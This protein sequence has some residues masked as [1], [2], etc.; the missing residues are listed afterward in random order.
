MLSVELNEKAPPMTLAR[1]LGRPAHVS[2]LASASN[3]LVSPV[4]VFP[5][6][7]LRWR[8]KGE[9][10]ITA[11]TLTPRSR[12]TLRVWPTKKSGL[13]FAWISI[14]TTLI[15][16][17]PPPNCSVHR[18][19]MRSGSAGSP[20]RNAANPCCFTS[21][22]WRNVLP[23]HRSPGPMFGS[24]CRRYPCHTLMPCPTGPD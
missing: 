19:W 11:A 7:S 20:F 9:R 10:H 1:K 2:G 16:F 12:P 15:T 18:A 14:R 6:G 13:H 5:T 8:W 24:I 21:R 22:R 17:G 4:N 3:A 23:R